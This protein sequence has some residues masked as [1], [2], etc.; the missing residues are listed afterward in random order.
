MKRH[1]LIIIIIIIRSLLSSYSC[2][3]VEASHEQDLEYFFD[4]PCLHLRPISTEG[5]DSH[6]II[7]RF[8]L[9][10]QNFNIFFGLLSKTWTT[11]VSLCFEYLLRYS[12]NHIFMVSMQ[13]SMAKRDYSSVFHQ[14]SSNLA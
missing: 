11:L 9:P 3:Y 12:K 10:L 5:C 2:F 4:S 13:Q 1:G 8:Y 14:E 6:E 7:S